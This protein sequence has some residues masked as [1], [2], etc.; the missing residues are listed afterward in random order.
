M[1]QIGGGRRVKAF[2]LL[3]TL[4]FIA[5][6]LS[7]NFL[8]NDFAK[9]Q[10]LDYSKSNPEITSATLAWPR[11]ISEENDLASFNSRLFKWQ[12]KSNFLIFRQM[13]DKAGVKYILIADKNYQDYFQGNPKITPSRCDQSVCQVI[14]VSKDG[15]TDIRA[16]IEGL[17]IVDTLKMAKDLP[18]PADFGVDKD[19]SLLITPLLDELSAWQPFRYLPATYGWQITPNYSA[20][21]A[22]QYQQE[23]QRLES[24]LNSEFANVAV[25]YEADKLVKLI[26]FEGKISSLSLHYLLTALFIF[27]LSLLIIWQRFKVKAVTTYLPFA[28]GIFLI[29]GVWGFSTLLQF[30]IYA[31][32]FGAFLF[33]INRLLDSYLLKR[34]FQSL[35]LFRS[36]LVTL[37]S[38]TVLIGIFSS[39]IFSASQYLMRT[40][41]IRSDLIDQQS[42]LDYTLK[43]D[44][45]LTRP[46]DLGSLEEIKALSNGGQLVPVIRSAASLID[47]NGDEIAVNLIA[48]GDALLEEPS[49]PIGLGRQVL[50]STKGIADQIDLIIWLKNQSG[51]H[52]SVV[53]TGKASRTG[54][55]PAERVGENFIVGFG[56]RLNP[57]YATTE[58]HALAESTGRSFEILNGRGQLLTVAVD[59]KEIP[60]QASWPIKSFTYELSDAAFILRPTLPAA[61]VNLV[62]SDEISAQIS[63]LKLSD[64]LLVAVD[65]VEVSEVVGVEKPYAVIDLAT[66]QSLLATTAPYS[67]DPLEIWVADGSNNFAQSFAASKFNSL[68]LI[69][70]DKLITAQENSPYWITWQKI[71]TTHLLLLLLLLLLPITYLSSVFNQDRR[72]KDWEFVN[73]FNAQAV[74][75]K[76]LIGLLTLGIPLG[77]ILLLA[78]R[79]I[80]SL[81]T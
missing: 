21:T 44:K 51:A 24:K 22:K 66:Y 31:S 18:I 32:L 2:A 60:I 61:K 49:L 55:I 68:K 29:Q 1:R 58:E 64:D 19:V 35:A 37:L 43:I 17:E 5:G 42:P 79:V 70:R 62:V 41:Q 76:P 8:N 71:F 63:Q 67:L 57:D 74:S 52:Y 26:S 65:Q 48:K 75:I 54:V 77:L 81:L 16:G 50:I 45:S 34:N 53:T 30:L 47:K 3:L 46:L 36:S 13:R 9:S 69:S 6:S 12:V 78:S 56:L 4:I 39:I 73:Y 27:L 15:L 33:V 59:G 72:G 25:N 14:A 7:L 28:A 80:A 40:E 38:I 11:L 23:L 10:L 20:L